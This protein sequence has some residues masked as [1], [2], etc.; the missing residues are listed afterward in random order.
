[1]CLG[2]KMA[3]NEMA[4]TPL[5]VAGTQ[6]PRYIRLFVRPAARP[7]QEPTQPDQTHSMLNDKSARTS[8][9]SERRFFVVVSD[10][11]AQ[12]VERV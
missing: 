11:C 5:A 6:W 1:M 10:D 12:N 8:L 7:T 3:A 9:A 2:A 4:A